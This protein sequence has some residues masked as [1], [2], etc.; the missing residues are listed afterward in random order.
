MPQEEVKSS[1]PLISSEPSTTTAQQNADSSELNK[2]CSILTQSY[3]VPLGRP[4]QTFAP[5]SRFSDVLAEEGLKK[6]DSFN[7]WMSKELGDDILLPQSI[8]RNYWDAT[9]DGDTAFESPE[10]SQDL[11]NSFMLGPS[12]SQ[13][14]L[15]SIVDFSPSWMY[16]GS[17][18]E[19]LVIPSLFSYF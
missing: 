9:T 5:R 11:D 14:Q 12:I 4:N 1:D 6:V 19:V 13:E 2:A 10:P 8:P 7:R 3:Q 15:F 18:I 17:A 16:T